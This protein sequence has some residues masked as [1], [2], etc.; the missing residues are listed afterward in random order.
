MVSTRSSCADV[1]AFAGTFTPGPNNAIATVT[2][3]N[4]SFRAAVPHMFGV[5]RVCLD[6]AGGSRRCGRNRAR[7]SACRTGLEVGRVAYLM[8][9]ALLLARSTQAGPAQLSG[10]FKLPLTFMQSAAFST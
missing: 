3:A 1:L 8:W 9:L 7:V 10:P 6:A 2:G 5:G 4:F